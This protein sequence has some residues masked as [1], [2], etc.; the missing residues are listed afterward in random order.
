MMTDKQPEALRLANN[1]EAGKNFHAPSSVWFDC[2]LS[3]VAKKAA[4]LLRT[5][6]AAIERKDALLRR[7]I[8][9]LDIDRHDVDDWPPD[10]CEAVYAIKQELSQ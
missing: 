7:L 8:T 4:A 9:A 6:H 5:Q 3:D 2:H 1:L 10:S